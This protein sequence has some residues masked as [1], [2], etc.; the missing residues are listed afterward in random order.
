MTLHLTRPSRRGRTRDAGIPPLVNGDHLK[1]PEFHRRYEAMPEGFKAELIGG[2]VYV[3]SPMRNPHG[4]H[5][6]LLSSLL[7]HYEA[8]TPGVEGADG[9]TVILGDESEPQ[10]DL[11]LRILPEHGGRSRENED[12][13]L[14]GPP[15]LLIEVA[16]ST[17]AIDLQ[18]KLADYRAGGVREYLVYCVKPG[19]LRAFQLGK[20]PTAV[21]D[22]TYRSVEFPGLWIDVAALAAKDV[23]RIL[24]AGQAGIASAEHS[25]FVERLRK[26]VKTRRQPAPRRR[27]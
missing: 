24:A 27:K 11:Y 2:I 16:H 7:G 9:V 6:R 25:K 17:E 18:G 5:T 10:P 1:Q 21:K 12:Q 23:R 22:G 20:E 19:E 3:A 8:E 4:R 14:T 26:K 13:Y 15:E